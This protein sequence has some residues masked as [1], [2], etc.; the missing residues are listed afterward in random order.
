[1]PKRDSRLCF[2]GCYRLRQ[3]WREMTRQ[4]Y[5]TRPLTSITTIHSMCNEEQI[6]NSIAA[7][8]WCSQQQYKWVWQL[9][10]TSAYHKASHLGN[11]TCDSRTIKPDRRDRTIAEINFIKSHS[12]YTNPISRNPVWAN[13][14]FPRTDQTSRHQSFHVRVVHSAR[15]PVWESI[16]SANRQITVLFPFASMLVGC[17]RRRCHWN[18]LS[19]DLIISWLRW[20][21]RRWRDSQRSKDMRLAVHL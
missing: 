18:G 7:L 11:R 19:S 17:W 21:L 3:A 16:L 14:L 4:I 15:Q 2:Q 1:M 6:C 12:D 20:R 9:A 5:C 8:N 10:A 13:Y